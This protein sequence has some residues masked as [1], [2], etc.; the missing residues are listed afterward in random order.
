LGPEA[1]DAL[2][3]HWVKLGRVLV[4]PLAEP[5]RPHWPAIAE[6]YAAELGCGAVVRDAGPIAGERRE[7]ARELVWGTQTETEVVEGGVRFAL[8]AARV[9][10]S[11]GNV[12]ERQ[13]IPRLV[14]EGEVVLDLF[15]GIG[16]FA[17]PI[18]AK[19]RPER[20]VAC[21]LNPVAFHC[22]QRNAALNHV[23]DRIEPRLGDCRATA[24]RGIADRVLLG[25]TV[26]TE[27][28]LPTAVAGLKRQGG[29]LHY[30]EACP[31]HLWRS[32]PEQRV[33]DAAA[34]AGREVVRAAP[35]VVK[36]YAPG[37]VH[38]VVDAEVR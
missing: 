3:R 5:L 32:R 2:P 24:P 33:R 35:R 28:F 1:L 30:H 31:A 14:Q 34:A 16:Y 37:M 26:E 20:V 27:R 23:Q 22:L 36:N 17:V 11:A 8:D 9:M 10:W 29:W 38:V 7:P 15:A 6:A 13:R 12:H 4:L 21:E 19:A 25:Y 18:A